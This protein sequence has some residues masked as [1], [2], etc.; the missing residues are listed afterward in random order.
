MFQGSVKILA[1]TFKTWQELI[2]AAIE[3]RTYSA[4]GPTNLARKEDAKSRFR[5]TGAT[6]VIVKAKAG[7]IFVSDAYKFV[8]N[9][10]VTA[11]W[12]AG[13]FTAEPGGGFLLP[14]FA[15]SQQHE[16]NSVQ[17]GN[18]VVYAAADTVIY[19]FVQ[20]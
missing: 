6:K 7:N 2:E 5:S 14:F 11:G 17:L 4:D 16:L 10:A 9:G 1:G 8:K 18:Q 12:V 13:D 19:V 3:A 20:Y 15:D